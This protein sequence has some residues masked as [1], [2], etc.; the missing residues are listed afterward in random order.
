MFLNPSQTVSALTTIDEELLAG[1][2][3]DEKPFET[4]AWGWDALSF[5]YH[6]GTQDVS[7]EEDITPEAWLERYIEVSTLRTQEG[8]H[9]PSLSA[10]EKFELPPPNTEQ[11]FQRS[12]GD[13]LQSRKTSRVFNGEPILLEELSTLLFT[14]F[15]K[16][17][18][19]WEELAQEGYKFEGFRRTSPSGGALHPVNPYVIC[20]HVSG[21]TP[22]VYYYNSPDHSLSFVSEIPDY[23]SLSRTLCSQYFVEGI[24]VGI[25]FTA[26]FHKAWTKYTHSRSYKD[27]YLDCG[28]LSQTCLLTATALNLKTWITAW[29]SDS[30]LSSLLHI[31]GIEVAPLAFIGI[32][33]GTGHFIPQ[34][35]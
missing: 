20:Y 21:L 29:F 26:F 33:H 28:H 30:R 24:A 2:L 23:T 16:F 7:N 11:L 4:A 14:T 25:V 3:I 8:P 15:G 32:G 27:I 1:G 34:K 31:S 35:K 9:V 5:I 18:G 19:E 22:G 6:I 10:S 13:I 12:Y 17:H